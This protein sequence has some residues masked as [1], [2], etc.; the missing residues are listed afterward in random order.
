MDIA[1]AAQ[2]R[3]PS[4][5]CSHPGCQKAFPSKPFLTHHMQSHQAPGQFPCQF[6]ERAYKTKDY[7]QRHVK[8]SHADSFIAPCDNA[9]LDFKC[10][11]CDD[12]FHDRN[13]LKIDHLN[14]SHEVDV[15][16]EFFKFSSLQ[17][18]KAFVDNIENARFANRKGD[19]HRSDSQIAQFY[20]CN[21][22][23][24]SIRR[25]TGERK[26]RLVRKANSIKV[27]HNCLAYISA[28]QLN[29]GT[30]EV[31]FMEFHTCCTQGTEIIF[32]LT[33][34]IKADIDAQVVQGLSVDRILKNMNSK[35]RNR[36]NRDETVK[37]Y[38]YGF[39]S[40]NLAINMNIRTMIV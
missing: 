2:V 16:K 1:S 27:F 20:V 6:C 18:F 30:V 17:D 32:R 15:E 23:K 9:S 40:D 10:N 13:C 26:E 22:S 5:A 11:F 28:L 24:E 12:A 35:F 25:T 3:P 14:S 39:Q 8:K 37:V 36:D 19:I 21:R 34:A 29:D 31:E 33:R 7:L 38:L 4:H